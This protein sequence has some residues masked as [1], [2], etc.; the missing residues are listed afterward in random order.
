MAETGFERRK[1]RAKRTLF[2]HVGK[3]PIIPISAVI[4]AIFLALILLS[5]FT[6]NF[7]TVQLFQRQVVTLTNSVLVNQ[8]KDLYTAASNQYQVVSFSNDELAARNALRQSGEKEFTY[9]NSI[10]FAVKPD[11]SYLFA[12]CANERYQTGLHFPDADVLAALETRRQEDNIEDGSLS[13]KTELGEYFGV[14]KYHPDWMAYFV[15][16]ELRTDTRKDSGRVF[17]ITCLIIAVLTIAFIIIGVVLFRRIFANINHITRSMY[18]MQQQQKLLQID[19]SNSS[20]D[21]ITYLAASFNAL[22]STINN[23]LG[24]FQKFVSQDV[25]KKAYDEHEIRLEGRQRDLVMLFSDIK[26]F[27][28]RTETLGNEIINLLNVHYDRVIHQVHVNRGVIGSIIGDAILAVYGTTE[29]QNKSLD[30]LVSAWEI[31]RVTA[32]LRRKMLARRALI[33]RDK[34]FSEAEDRVFRA[35]LIDV[36]VGIDGGTVFYGNIGSDEHMTNTVI[37]DRVNSSS[38]LEGLTRVYHLPVIVSDYI[39]DEVLSDTDQYHFYEIDTVQVK[40]KTEGKKIYFPLD[41]RNPGEYDESEFKLYAEALAAYYEGDWDAARSLFKS[42]NLEVK[43]VFLERMGSKNAP[44]G[45][46]G[47]WTMTSK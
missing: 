26:S 15:R 31:T 13:F 39:K 1:A 24:I 41:T 27:T 43:Q 9:P 36:G 47:I 29:G 40:G 22:S 46:S 21:D 5:T 4:L 11:G 35:V 25:V 16:A 32:A 33:E 7:L 30:A 20:N 2:Q 45:W 3:T 17:R 10:A 42:V 12:V 34:P 6:T 38:R 18:E 19:L 23:L 28:Y 44:E 14:Y 8:L 37:G